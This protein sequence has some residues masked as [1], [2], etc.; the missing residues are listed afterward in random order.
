[1]ITDACLDWLILMGKGNT[2][3]NRNIACT[4][5]EV[6]LDWLVYFFWGKGGGGFVW[7]VLTR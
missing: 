3:C 2:L 5:T 1:M 6:R 7:L 4:L